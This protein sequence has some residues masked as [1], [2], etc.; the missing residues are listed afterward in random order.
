[1]KK[2]IASLFFLF[3]GVFAFANSSDEVFTLD[4]QA[5]NNEFKGL[6]K[7]ESY[8]QQHDGVSLEQVQQANPSVLE[9]VNIEKDSVAGINHINKEMPIVGGFWWGCLLSVLGLALV[10][11]I[12]DN[13]SQQVKAA[14][15]GCLLSA[16]LTGGGLL[17]SPF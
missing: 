4:R 7:V 13:D 6:E 15:W 3:T 2:I 5:L 12:T 16:L 11:F 17:W 1:M 10:Y 8:V 9:N 14:L